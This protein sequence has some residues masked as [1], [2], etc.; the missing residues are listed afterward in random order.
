MSDTVLNLFFFFLKRTKHAVPDDKSS[1]IILINILL[2]RTMV[3]TVIGWCCKYVFY[4]RVQPANVFS[5]YP[6]L[7][8]NTNLVYDKKYDWVKTQECHRGKKYNL[9]VLYPTKTKR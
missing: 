8:Q 1:C 5:M 7:K 9:Q 6:E 2:L 4:H 3:H